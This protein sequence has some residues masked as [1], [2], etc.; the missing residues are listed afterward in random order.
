MRHLVTIEL[1]DRAFVHLTPEFSQT[2]RSERKSKV[3][4]ST[5]K[6]LLV[7]LSKSIQFRNWYGKLHNRN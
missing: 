5:T 2:I 6:M 1:I 4:S 7:S 3:F